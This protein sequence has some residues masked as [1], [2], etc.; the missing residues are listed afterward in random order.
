VQVTF[1]VRSEFARRIREDSIAT[2]ETQGLLGDKYLSISPGT[3]A[4]PPAPEGSLLRSKEPADIGEVLGKA[5]VI[6][7]NVSEISESLL[8][9]FKGLDKDALKNFSEGAK[10]F[11]EISKGLKEG[12]GLIHRLFYSKKD[13]DKIVGNLVKASES[14]AELSD[15]IKNGDGFLHSIIF[16]K[17]DKNL[18]SN[19]TEAANSLSHAA[20]FISSLSEEIKSGNGML[21]ELVY[22]DSGKII[23]DLSKTASN[24]REASDAIKSVSRSLK[25]GEGTLGALLVDSKL[26]D[27]LVEV[28]DGAKRSFILKQAIR[29]SLK[30]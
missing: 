14:L 26:Y 27:N 9:S 4:I 19:L 29:S 3:L 8:A 6:I 15:E 23:K 10:G 11:A 24:L 2:I 28:T 20:K 16:E 30:K 21:H 12:K 13:A 1:A 25:N 5:Q 7:A 22:G 18:F 17:T